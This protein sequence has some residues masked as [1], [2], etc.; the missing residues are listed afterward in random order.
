VPLKKTL[1]RIE[2][3]QTD[4][5]VYAIVWRRR[6]DDPGRVEVVMAGR[7]NSPFDAGKGKCPPM[8]PAIR[9]VFDKGRPAVATMS[10]AVYE[11]VG[12]FRYGHV[13]IAANDSLL[14]AGRRVVSCFHPVRDSRDD[15]VAALEI[16][17]VGT[18]N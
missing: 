8:F 11:S 3:I 7:M 2:K 12:S 9:Q 10:N 14:R 13:W 6:P 15:V 17:C 1:L 16:A 18:D 5:P 4:F